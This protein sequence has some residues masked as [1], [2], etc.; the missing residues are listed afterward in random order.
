MLRKQENSQKDYLLMKRLNIYLFNR[1]FSEVKNYFLLN[2][3]SWIG[4]E[5]D[6]NNETLYLSVHTHTK[7]LVGFQNYQATP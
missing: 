2:D 6:F 1:L 5:S 7:N 4:D 3:S